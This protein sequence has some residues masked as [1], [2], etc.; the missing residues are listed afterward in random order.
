MSCPRK[1]QSLDNEPSFRPL[2]G[3]LA[4]ER[5]RIARI[6]AGC[7]GLANRLAS[8]GLMVNVEITVVNNGHPGPFVVGVRESKVVLGRGMADR[9]MVV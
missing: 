6:S 7:R 4:G 2:S 8:M 1:S 3:V 9:I 5:V